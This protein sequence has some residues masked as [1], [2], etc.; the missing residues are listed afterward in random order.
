MANNLAGQF[1]LTAAKEGQS[2]TVISPTNTDIANFSDG[3][4]SDT[5]ADFTVTINWGD[6]TTSPGTVVGGDGSFTVEADHTYADEGTPTGVVTITRTTDGAQLVLQGNV[7]VDDTDTLN[8]QVTPTIV[9]NANQAL[10]NVTV[11]T[12]SDPTYP[13]NVPSDFT[14]N[15]DWGDGTT[16]P[17]TISG[18][19]GTFTITGSH[20]YTTAG[21]F[22]I[23]SFMAD[24]APDAASGAATTTAD[25]G[26]GGV[27]TPPQGTFEFIALPTGTQ[28]ATFADNAGDPATDYTATIDWGD[29]TTT[30]GSVSGSGGSFTVTSA[31]PHTYADE[32]NFTEIVTITN[33]ANNTSITISGTEAVAEN[34]EL[35]AVGTTITGSPGVSTG[36]VTVATFRDTTLTA[37]NGASPNVAS[38]FV[39]T[40]NWGDG[41]TSTGAI[42]GS[43][44]AFTVT[45]AHTYANNG[46]FSVVVDVSE[47]DNGQAVAS[48]SAQSSA[49][50]GLAAVAGSSTTIAEGTSVAAGT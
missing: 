22:L 23:T 17:G 24:V 34:D 27:V 38:D 32:G 7:A 6:G 30:A 4:Q 2:L 44:L 25:I 21:Q 9:A 14:A 15:I 1:D 20:T 3:F 11:A 36:N 39:A 42:S 49:L 31:S 33:T 16:T 28:V 40:V 48:T 35:S 50:I 8:A 10:T 45:G 12:F 47:G 19:S 41:T 43:G 18:G 26:F 13:G 46:Q 37:P 29:G 5:A